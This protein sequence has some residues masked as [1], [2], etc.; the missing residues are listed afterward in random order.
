MKQEK[1]KEK[2]R[3]A[4]VAMKEGK[5][6]KIQD[7][8]NTKNASAG[9]SR[10][11]QSNVTQ[12]PGGAAQTQ[13]TEESHFADLSNSSTA[14]IIAATSAGATRWTRFRSAVCCTSAQNVD[15]RH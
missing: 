11:S 1:E 10:P 13:P 9:N 5:K 8:R 2:A 12:Q 7:S 15:G 4:K 3:K 14:P 6:Q